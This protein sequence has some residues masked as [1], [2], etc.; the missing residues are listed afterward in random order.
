MLKAVF[1]RLKA[2]VA[3]ASQMMRVNLIIKSLHTERLGECSKPVMI[4]FVIFGILSTPEL[5]H[6]FAKHTIKLVP[7]I[8]NFACPHGL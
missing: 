3:K 5:Y 7:S 6:V 2:H 1:A 4:S 8:I